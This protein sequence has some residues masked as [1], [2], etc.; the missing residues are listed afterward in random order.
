VTR[1]SEYDTRTKNILDGPPQAPYKEFRRAIKFILDTEQYGLKIEPRI[2]ENS[3]EPWDL[4]LFSDSDWAGNKDTRISV[5]GYVI[6]LLG[7]PI[8]WKSKGQKSVTLSS[9][10][11]E[12][13]TL[14]EAAKEVKCIVQILLSM[15]IPGA[16]MVRGCP[17]HF[18]IFGVRVPVP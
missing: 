15:G 6:F 1:Y 2:P 18:L 8:S 7:V 17:Q 11:T 9:S 4:I 10:E 12:F 13:A 16:E 14:T 5:S 3:G